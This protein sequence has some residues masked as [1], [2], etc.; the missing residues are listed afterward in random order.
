MKVTSYAVARPAYYDRT[1]VSILLAY[2]GTVAPHA[3]TVRIT[4]TVAA[5]RKTAI[6]MSSYVVYRSTVA[7]VAGLYGVYFN[8]VGSSTAQYSEVQYSDNTAGFKAAVTYPL[9]MTLYAGEILRG[10]TYDFSTG[11]AT[12]VLLG[13]KGTNYDA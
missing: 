12:R 3:D 4:S 2:D 8:I 1:A 6:E 10:S 5:G 13:T 7:T 9:Q 11:G